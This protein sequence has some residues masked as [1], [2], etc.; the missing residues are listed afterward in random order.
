MVWVFIVSI[1]SKFSI[2]FNFMLKL[3]LFTLISLILFLIEV[4]S[5]LLIKRSKALWYQP[6]NFIPFTIIL[7][8]LINIIMITPFLNWFSFPNQ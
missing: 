2:I 1:T 3:E 5:L 4:L 8:S 6:L 7:K